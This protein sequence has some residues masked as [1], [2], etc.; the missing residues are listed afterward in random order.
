MESAGMAGLRLRGNLEFGE[1]LEIFTLP[2]IPK[3]KTKTKTK[4]EKKKDHN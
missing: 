1:G 3:T 2:V 4:K